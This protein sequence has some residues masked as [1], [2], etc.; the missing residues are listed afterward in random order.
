MLTYKK[1]CHHLTLVELLGSSSYGGSGTLRTHLPGFV[2]HRPSRQITT[3]S[4]FPEPLRLCL[5]FSASPENPI[6]PKLLGHQCWDHLSSLKQGLPRING[7][8]SNWDPPPSGFPECTNE[9]YIC[10]CVWIIHPCLFYTTRAHLCS[11]FPAV[12]TL[13][14]VSPVHRVGVNTFFFFISS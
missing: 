5:R 6:S 7:L 11:I 14:M 8:S 3:Q 2:C 9:G 13:P 1:L 12:F 4:S 10:F